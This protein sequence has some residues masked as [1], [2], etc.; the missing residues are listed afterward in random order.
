MHCKVFLTLIPA[1]FTLSTKAQSNIH[2]YGILDTGIGY[3]KAKESKASLR[4]GDLLAPRLGFKGREFINSD[5]EINF[6]LEGT[7]SIDNGSGAPTNTNNQSSG[8][9]S[10]SD[11]KF[12]RQSWVGFKSHFGELRFGRNF[13]PTYRQYIAYD[14]FQGGGPAA[15]QIAQSSFSTHG[16]P[17]AGIRHSNA[18]E[19]W[20]INEKIS[21]QLMYAMGEN[22]SG[23]NDGDYLA[24]RL[25]FKFSESDFG[26]AY[27]K[28][29]NTSLKD[30]TEISIGGSH[31]F[32][33][34]NFSALLM[35]S[36]IGLKDKQHGAMLAAV[37]KEGPFEYRLSLSQSKTK[38]SLGDLNAK[39]SKVA[40]A[41]IYSLSKRSS[42]YTLG[43]FVRNSHGAASSPLGTLS[44]QE[45]GVNHNVKYISLGLTHVF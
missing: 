10:S 13:N 17:I 1:F 40:G 38:N 20:F 45:T 42:I 44:L 37:Y 26:V 18:I 16:Y 15:S 4:G 36:K 3:A 30:I 22:S 35:T 34:V 43:A 25:S 39:S 29:K 27:A 21:T 14:P 32:G 9:S 11:F 12:N 24:S 2:I 19:Y 31:K 7:V 8:L 5:L 33:P 28:N 23:S 41:L 6:A